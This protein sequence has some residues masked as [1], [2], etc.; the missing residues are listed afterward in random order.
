MK[1]VKDEVKDI[2]SDLFR[3]RTKSI[4]DKMHHTHTHTHTH[5]DTHSKR[6]REVEN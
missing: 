1:H 6:E 4:T 3:I 5:T 2:S